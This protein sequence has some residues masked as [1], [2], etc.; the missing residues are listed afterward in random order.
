M[1]YDIRDNQHQNSYYFNDTIQI[2]F[3]TIKS[4]CLFLIGM[5]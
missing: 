1:Y 4:R 5:N 2:Y 3:E